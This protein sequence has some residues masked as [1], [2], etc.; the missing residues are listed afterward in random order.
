MCANAK[1]RRRRKGRGFGRASALGAA[2]AAVAGAGCRRELNPYGPPAGDSQAAAAASAS[3]K[4]SRK[5]PEGTIYVELK[6]VVVDPNL[7]P[8]VA[9]GQVFWVPKQGPRRPMETYLGYLLNGVTYREYDRFQVA[10]KRAAGGELAKHGDKT[11]AVFIYDSRMNPEV[12]SKVGAEIGAAGVKNVQ[13]V[14]KR[15]VSGPGGLGFPT[16]RRR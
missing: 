9:D 16:R 3:S 7:E 1:D 11:K 6:P 10:L 2:L 8:K 14:Q 12:V 13:N 4:A 5:P 15:D